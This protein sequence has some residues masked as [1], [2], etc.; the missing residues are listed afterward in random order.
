VRGINATKNSRWQC[1]PL[2]FLTSREAC[3]TY[4]RR[5]AAATSRACLAASPP[6]SPLAASGGFRTAA[7]RQVPR[8]PGSNEWRS[9]RDQSRPSTSQTFKQLEVRGGWGRGGEAEE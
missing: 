7:V 5:S 9:T 4:S 1:A 3:A 2:L 8:S 6:P